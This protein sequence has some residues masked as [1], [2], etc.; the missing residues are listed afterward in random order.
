MKYA[1]LLQSTC[2]LKGRPREFQPETIREP[3]PERHFVVSF[4][5][6]RLCDCAGARAWLPTSGQAARATSVA[7]PHRTLEPSVGVAG[8]LA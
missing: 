6:V 2:A 3:R 4:I 7:L 8:G 1:K 5:S